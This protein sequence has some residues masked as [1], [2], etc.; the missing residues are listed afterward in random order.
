MIILM[1]YD[2]SILISIINY[3]T[4]IIINKDLYNLFNKIIEL[5]FKEE[6]F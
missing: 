2:K 6:T 3:V 1:I 5:I 4:E